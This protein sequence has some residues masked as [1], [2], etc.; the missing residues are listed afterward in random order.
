MTKV[1][2]REMVSSEL[3]RMLEDVANREVP[4]QVA[5]RDILKRLAAANADGFAEG[6]EF[7]T[8][9]LA[10]ASPAH[11]LPIVYGDSLPVKE[12]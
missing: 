10:V 8:S 4:C 2:E 5:Y 7:T 11:G 12:T 9:E 3:L 1:E 6:V